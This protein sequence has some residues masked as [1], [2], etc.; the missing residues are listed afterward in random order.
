[1]AAPP[2]PSDPSQGVLGDDTPRSEKTGRPWVLTKK[3]YEYYCEHCETPLGESWFRS[4]IYKK[5]HFRAGK[6]E[7]REVTNNPTGKIYLVDLDSVDEYLASGPRHRPKPQ[8]S[9]PVDKA[10]YK[11]KDAIPSVLSLI[12]FQRLVHNGH[13]PS[14]VRDSVLYVRRDDIFG[15]FNKIEEKGAYVP[16]AKAYDYYFEKATDPVAKSGFWRFI[17]DGLVRGRKNGGRLE[18]TIQAVDDFLE[19]YPDGRIRA[20]RRS[21][22]R[23]NVKAAPAPAPQPKPTPPPAPAPHAVPTL[24]P[25][26][27][28]PPAQDAKPKIVVR[29]S[30]YPTTES[31]SQTLA[32]LQGQGFEVEV[33][34]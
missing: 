1:V 9:W 15:Y 7:G 12:Q 16:I 4:Q 6:Y 24:P 8:Q 5:R 18:T 11:F 2:P 23:K 14:F 13:I 10:F 30:D 27:T 28:P 33:K 25:R 32:T 22:S 17:T 31:L 20:N 26:R 34:P 19:K 29:I 3:A 21:H